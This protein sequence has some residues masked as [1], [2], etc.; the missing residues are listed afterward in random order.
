MAQ[1]LNVFSQALQS[2]VGIVLKRVEPLLCNDCEISKYARAISSQRLGK[3]VTAAMNRGVCRITVEKR[4]FYFPSKWVIRRRAEARLKFT[5]EAEK[6][7]LL[8][9]VTR[10]RLVKTMHAGKDLVCTGV[11]CKL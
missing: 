5:T 4:C 1:G 2:N 11:T 6:Q 8:E 3:H 7:A 9:A 10:E